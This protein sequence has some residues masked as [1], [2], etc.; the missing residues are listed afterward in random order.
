[1]SILEVRSL[2]KF[3]PHVSAAIRSPLFQ[4]FPFLRR[5]ENM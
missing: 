4:T 1:M 5:R 2:K 3:I